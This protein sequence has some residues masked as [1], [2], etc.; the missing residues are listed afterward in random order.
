AEAVHAVVHHVGAAAAAVAAGTTADTLV[1]ECAGRVAVA[2]TARTARIGVAAVR[3]RWL[4]AAGLAVLG[5]T[6]IAA[7]HEG[8]RAQARGGARDAGNE[9]DEDRPAQRSHVMT[10]VCGAV[11]VNS[12]VPRGYAVAHMSRVRAT[13]LANR[14]AVVGAAIVV[15][16]VLLAVVGPFL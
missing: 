2:T 1:G 15:V 9:T 12:R 11:R 7:A 3:R 16:L 13:L 8:R 6:L 5:A 14:G 4:A 10:I